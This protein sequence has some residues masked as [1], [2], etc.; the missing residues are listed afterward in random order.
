MQLSLGRLRVS[1]TCHKACLW[2]LVSQQTSPTASL[3][4]LHPGSALASTGKT[5]LGRAGARRG[6]QEGV[7]EAGRRHC[8]AGEGRMRS[9]LGLGFRGIGFHQILTPLSTCLTLCQVSWICTTYIAGIPLPQGDYQLPPNLC[10][11]QHGPCSL[12]GSR[13]WLGCEL[14]APF[15][16]FV[17]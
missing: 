13:L 1:Q 4:V 10:L 11:I 7:L 9:G 3:A 2:L 5:V 12:C 6:C 14:Y 8:W 15:P 16:H 17:C